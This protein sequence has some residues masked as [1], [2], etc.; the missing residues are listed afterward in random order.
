MDDKDRKILQLLQQNAKLRIDQMARRTGIAAT[1]VHSRIKGMEKKGI[2][3]GYTAVVDNEK[4]G[5]P[6]EAYILVTVD[7]SMLKR[8]KLSQPDLGRRLKGIEGVEEACLI[9]GEKDL[10]LRVRAESIKRLSSTI[11]DRIR[12]VEGVEKTIT[13]IVLERV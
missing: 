5:K 1:T 13:L 10:V 7:Y 12:R 3:T 11:T 2:I 8:A 9:A 6:V 4:L